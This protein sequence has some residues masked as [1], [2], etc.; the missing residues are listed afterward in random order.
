MEERGTVGRATPTPPP[1]PH[2]HPLPPSPR[3]PSVPSQIPL[4]LFKPIRTPRHDSVQTS[5]TSFQSVLPDQHQS[6]DSSHSGSNTI[7]YSHP[8]RPSSLTERTLTAEPSQSILTRS[9]TL[10]LRHASMSSLSSPPLDPVRH[11]TPLS[12]TPQDRDPGVIDTPAPAPPSSSQIPSSSL[13]ASPARSQSTTQVPQTSQAPQAPQAPEFVP[14]YSPVRTRSSKKELFP[15]YEKP[16]R[17]KSD[18]KD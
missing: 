11:S 3:L 5:E 9:S 17:K 14:H 10:S 7:L 6:R 2:P 16:K 12:N 8:S 15:A 13:T 18:K 4:S 1:H